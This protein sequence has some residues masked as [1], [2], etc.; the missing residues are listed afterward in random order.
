MAG[1]ILQEEQFVKRRAMKNIKKYYSKEKNADRKSQI[2]SIPN[3][4]LTLS[5]PPVYF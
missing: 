2:M 4:F 3:R 1:Y 5:M